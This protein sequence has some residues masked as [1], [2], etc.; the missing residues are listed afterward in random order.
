MQPETCSCAPG[1]TGQ[2]CITG[3]Y[4]YKIYPVV[5]IQLTG[6]VPAGF[7]LSC[8]AYMVPFPSAICTGGCLNGGQCV[9]P[10]TCRC[11]TGRTG[12]NCET[13]TY[14]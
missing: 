10:E 1:W 8:M 5:Y 13:G 2:N 3:M 14:L 12:Q 7:L 11:A 4:L 9:Q 6:N